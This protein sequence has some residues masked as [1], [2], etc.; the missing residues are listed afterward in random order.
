MCMNI[1]TRMNRYFRGPHHDHISLTSSLW[2]VQ[3]CIVD[4]TRNVPLTYP[5]SNLCTRTHQTQPNTSILIFNF[6][7]HKKI[8]KKKKEEILS[9]KIL[10]KTVIYIKGC[11]CA[12]RNIPTLP[13]KGL[14]F[15]LWHSMRALSSFRNRLP[16]KLYPSASIES[17][18]K[19]RNIMSASDESPCFSRPRMVAK[20]VHGKLSH[21]GDGAVVRRAIGR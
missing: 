15:L 9:S 20:K 19:I 3:G 16:F 6:L 13:T 12:K 11:S 14:W 18:N 7:I 4:P 17:N 10:P 1:L 8:F 21:D 5:I 2:L